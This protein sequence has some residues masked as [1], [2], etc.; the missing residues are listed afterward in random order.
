MEKMTTDLLMKL[1]SDGIVSAAETFYTCSN[2]DYNDFMITLSKTK[3]SENSSYIL[4]AL[5]TMTEDDLA[6]ACNEIA[7]ILNSV[8]SENQKEQIN[9]AVDAAKSVMEANM[10]KENEMFT[11]KEMAEYIKTNFNIK[12]SAQIV[13]KALVNL[14]YQVKDPNIRYCPTAKAYKEDVYQYEMVSKH[15]T[16]KWSVALAAKILGVI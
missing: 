10:P 2:E 11:P 15:S 3:F 14:G 13:N 5:L 6:N 16:L 7:E 1:Y 8:S 9:S 4:A 12:C